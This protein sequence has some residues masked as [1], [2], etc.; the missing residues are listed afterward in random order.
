M[1]LPKCVLHGPT[2]L[3]ANF[4]F[5]HIFACFG[6]VFRFFT[7]LQHKIMNFVRF[8]FDKSRITKKNFKM[9]TFHVIIIIPMLEDMNMTSY[10]LVRCF[11]IFLLFHPRVVNFQKST[12]NRSKFILISIYSYSIHSI[13]YILYFIFFITTY[14]LCVK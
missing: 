3:C 10:L 13:H 2:V 9:Y 12:T 4:Y 11:L 14:I 5:M 6:H 1:F 7:F 8:Q